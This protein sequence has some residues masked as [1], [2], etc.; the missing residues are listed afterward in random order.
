MR[1]EKLEKNLALQ[2]LN[3]CSIGK[4]RSYITKGI[5]DFMGSF[6]CRYNFCKSKDSASRFINFSNNFAKYI[7]IT[8]ETNNIFLQKKIKQRLRELNVELNKTKKLLF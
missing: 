5:Y 4:V 8:G 6:I 1:L 3:A 2:A 7:L